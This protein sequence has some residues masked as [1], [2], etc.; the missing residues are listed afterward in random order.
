V[1]NHPHIA[2]AGQLGAAG[3]Q[4]QQLSAVDAAAVARQGGPE[5]ALGQALEPAAASGGAGGGA[6]AAAG[7]AS[8]HVG[9]AAA[10]QDAAAAAG[11][12]AGG[13]GEAG[14][15]GGHGT[16]GAKRERDAAAPSSEAPI[17]VEPAVDGCLV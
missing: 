3:A 8:V 2:R 12:D 16:G 5:E 1:R 15:S 17:P 7:E 14:A 13:S 6:A 11:G 9:T 10:G 4:L